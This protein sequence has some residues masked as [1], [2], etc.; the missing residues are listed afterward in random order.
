MIRI[1]AVLVVLTAFA[2]PA[3][4]GLPLHPGQHEHIVMSTKRAH[5]T[6][7]SRRK[8]PGSAQAI[9]DVSFNGHRPQMVWNDSLQIVEFAY[10]G[11]IATLSFRKGT[12]PV[13]L[14]VASTGSRRVKVR[15]TVDWS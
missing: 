11:T 7:T 9:V 4:A 15:A 6:I 1:A 8:I 14:R 10:H 13:T 12:G 3:V 5:V 2:S